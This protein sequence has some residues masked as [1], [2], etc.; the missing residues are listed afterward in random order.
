MAFD[1]SIALD[2]NNFNSDIQTGVQDALL[3]RGQV[4]A[5]ALGKKIEELGNGKKVNAAGD[6]TTA[7]METSDYMVGQM[8]IGQLTSVFEA[9]NAANTVN[10]QKMSD[11]AKKVEQGARG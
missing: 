1:P 7:N 2:G 6:V 10:N 11:A 8:Q 3:E 9:I 4:A 5:D